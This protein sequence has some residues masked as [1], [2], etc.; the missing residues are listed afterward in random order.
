VY[1][2]QPT[3]FCLTILLA[4]CAAAFSA[5][6]N[7]LTTCVN[8]GL[9]KAYLC[10][11]NANNLQRDLQQACGNKCGPQ[12]SITNITSTPNCRPNVSDRTENF[13]SPEEIANAM[14][15][16]IMIVRDE[17]ENRWAQLCPRPAQFC[18]DTGI[19]L[20]AGSRVRVITTE[21][22][23]YMYEGHPTK[24]ECARFDPRR[25][26]HR[27]T[28]AVIVVVMNRDGTLLKR[29]NGQL[30]HGYIWVSYLDAPD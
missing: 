11:A 2:L 22:T 1:L 24:L 19:I 15:K 6:S 20:P 26:D 3:L 9:C 5:S 28:C 21:S 14:N 18:D 8:P 16:P 27:S 13:L 4:C 7:Y 17:N 30:V 23:R 29:S 25:N 10:S 12:A